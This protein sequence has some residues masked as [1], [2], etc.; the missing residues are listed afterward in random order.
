MRLKMS[1]KDYAF[2]NI[3]G[4]RHVVVSMRGAHRTLLHERSLIS[5]YYTHRKK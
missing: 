2:P 3:L 1:S 5:S 4:E